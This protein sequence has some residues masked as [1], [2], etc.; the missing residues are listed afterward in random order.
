LNTAEKQ[1]LK[2]LKYD[3]NATHMRN[4]LL[5]CIKLLLT[6]LQMSVNQFH[7]VNVMTLAIH[8]YPHKS[9]CHTLSTVS[10][11]PIDKLKKETGLTYTKYFSV[12]LLLG[13][14]NNTYHHARVHCED[15]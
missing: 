15:Q 8:T 2:K 11:H 6:V 10:T 13:I 9:Q 4:S 3:D 5:C 12:D 14:I 1:N 7:V